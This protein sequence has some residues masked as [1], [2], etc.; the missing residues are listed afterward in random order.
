MYAESGE[1]GGARKV[2]DKM[3]D[4]GLVSWNALIACH[5]NNAARVFEEIREPDVVS[6]TAM[7]VG[8]MQN[9]CEKDAMSEF[10]W[11]RC[12]DWNPI[13]LPLFGLEFDMV[14]G[15]AIIDMYSE[16]GE[17]SD[18]FRLF[19]SMPE[20]DF[21]SWNGIICGFAQSGEGMKALEPFDEMVR[22]SLFNDMINV[23]KIE[24]TTEHYTCIIDILARAGH[25][26]EAEAFLLAL[27]WKPDSVMWG[28]FARG[29]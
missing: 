18:A 3:P 14:V 21:V 24:P 9:G 27:P 22:P 26:K 2:F 15:S 11:M 4:R 10:E 12:R 17:M 28:A 19:Q 6:W 1:M 13:L 5:S 16:C 20:K 29:L 7:L 8:L 25:L 23:Y